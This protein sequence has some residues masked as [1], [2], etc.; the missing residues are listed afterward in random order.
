MDKNWRGLRRPL[1]AIALALL[2]FWLFLGAAN[3][4]R[5][6]GA[7]VGGS[8]FNLGGLVMALVGLGM[9]VGILRERPRWAPRL[10]LA[11][12][13]LPL[14]LFQ[15][16]VSAELLSVRQIRAALTGPPAPD[17]SA[18]LGQEERARLAASARRPI[19]DEVALR[20]EFLSVSRRL[21]VRTEEHIAYATLCHRRAWLAVAPLPAWLSEAERAEVA[22][23]GNGPRSATP[24]P[25]SE[26]TSET[27]MKALAEQ[28]MRDRDLADII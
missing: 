15:A 5:V 21:R 24:P 9:A 11:A 23:A 1:M 8:R 16:A 14:C 20:D 27:L 12:L 2:P 17:P 4:V 28:A 26:A 19:L 10:V 6:N 7:L 13:A 22:A 25:C 18:G 3:E